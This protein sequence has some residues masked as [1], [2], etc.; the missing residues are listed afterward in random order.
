MEN[1]TDIQAKR[2]KQSGQIKQ[3]DEDTF[4]GYASTNTL[5]RDNEIIEPKAF[6]K[7][8]KQFINTGVILGGHWTTSYE[9]KSMVIGKPLDAKIDDK[10]LF[11]KC[12]YAPGEL[13]EQYKQLIKGGF[14]T[15]F[16][17]GFIARK[18]EDTQDENGNRGPR[19]FTEVELLEVSVVA[20][21]CNREAIISQRGKALSND[22][23]DVLIKS[24]DTPPVPAAKGSDGAEEAIDQVYRR[25][26]DTQGKQVEKLIEMV[27]Q[28]KD[29]QVTNNDMV[30]LF[31]DLKAE[32]LDPDGVYT[33]A[34]D[35]AAHARADAT[36]STG[37]D[38]G[39]K[40][41]K[42]A[43]ATASVAKT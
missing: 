27:K 41:A 1:K 35:N 36:G 22:M 2:Y 12:A 25:L 9:G 24:L 13:G 19:I 20:I 40:L 26:L 38:I 37:P 16:S 10:G 18:W 4:E 33:R 14:L 30:L 8:L 39:N 11:I 15:G 21:P 23:A 7:S 31:E 32:I 43:A 28:L 34:L 5:D 42:L 17:V 29:E 3:V 6:K